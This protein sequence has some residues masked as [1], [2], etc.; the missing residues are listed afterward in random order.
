MGL[1]EEFISTLS[2]RRFGIEIECIVPRNGARSPQDA[3][4]RLRRHL[5]AHDY[6]WRRQWLIEFRPRSVDDLCPLTGWQIKSDA[7]I[8]P[9]RR[10]YVGAELISPILSG[11]P[12]LRS[13]YFMC[14]ALRRID[15]DINSSCGI[16]VHHDAQDLHDPQLLALAGMWK[17]SEDLIYGQLPPRR[18]SRGYSSPLPHTPQDYFRSEQRV[19]QQT[20]RRQARAMPNPEIE[21]SIDYIFRRSD[22]GFRV[23]LDPM[24]TQARNEAPSPRHIV[25]VASLLSQYSHYDGLNL[26]AAQQRHGTVEARVFEASLHAPTICAWIILTQR[27]IDRAT[28]S[29][30]EYRPR[31]TKSFTLPAFRRLIYGAPPSKEHYVDPIPVAMQWFAKRVRAYQKRGQQR[32]DLLNKA[33]DYVERKMRFVVTNSLL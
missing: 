3:R 32:K 18:G 5:S 12:G 9:R 25:P 1:A 22:G 2:A 30:L 11:L 14:D 17:K 24:I 28:S 7:S 21:D 31:L 27:I 20:Q 23:D 33:A 4:R 16:H 19:Q 29:G 8:N 15:A 10:G 13:V 6:N 26:Y